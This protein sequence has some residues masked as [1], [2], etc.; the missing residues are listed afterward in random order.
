MSDREHFGSNAAAILSL[1]GSA[2]GL[3]NIWRFPYMVGEYGGAAFIVVYVLA[4]LFLSI[5][6]ML[7]EA[8]IGRRSRQNPF[9]AMRSMSKN[10]VWSRMAIVTVLAPILILSF[11]SVVGGWSVKYLLKSFSLPLASSD[12]SIFSAEFAEFISAPY[13]PLLFHT[14]FLLLCALIVLGGIKSGIEKFNKFTMPLLFLLI[15][16][17]AV[18]SCMLPGAKGGID[19]L[20]RPDFS[21]LSPQGIASAVGQSFFSLSLGVGTVLTYSSYIA[22]KDNLMYSALGT[23]GFDLLFAL[24]AGFAVMPAVFAAG[25]TPGAGPGLIFETVPYIFAQMGANAPWLGATVSLLF[26]LAICFAAL[27]SAI[28][29]YEVGVTYMV[30]EKHISRKKAVVLIFFIAWGLGILC[31]LSFGAL[32]DLKIF[33]RCIFDFCDYLTS[34][35]LMMFGGLLTVLFAGWVMKRADVWDEFTNSGTLSVNKKVFPI[36]YF[37]MKY[38]APIGIVIIFVTNFLP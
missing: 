27:S 11:Y 4:S 32:S 14:I 29:L 28:S 38:L 17:M 31:S 1:A 8:V 7:S 20:L 36:V 16:L 33:G 9:G 21:K 12:A 6:I 22:S 3:G 24:L 35:Y 15:V 13:A 37:L 23:T 34:N 2:I 10:P 5:P 30:E 26:F 19:Y 18:F 25:A